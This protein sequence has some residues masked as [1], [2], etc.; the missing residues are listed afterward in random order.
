MDVGADILQSSRLRAAVEP[1]RERQDDAPSV[2]LFA[3]DAFV[4]RGEF[5]GRLGER[6]L[7]RAVMPFEIAFGGKQIPLVI[8]AAMRGRRQSFSLGPES[9]RVEKKP[10]RGENGDR[11]MIERASLAAKNRFR[12]N[13]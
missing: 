4:K 9:V 10:E 13:D 1:A 2:D 11:A 3:D 6:D 8:N 7:A 5:F 12:R